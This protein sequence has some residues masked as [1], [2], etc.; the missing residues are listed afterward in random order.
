M[1]VRGMKNSKI[2]ELPVT[3]T[4]H[5]LYDVLPAS[6]YQCNISSRSKAGMSDPSNRLIAF[7]LCAIPDAP[8]SVEILKGNGRRSI[9]HSTS[10]TLQR[11][12]LTF[13]SCHFDPSSIL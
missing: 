13:S 4:V 3:Q 5:T 12:L 10:F 6:S 7:T 1:T 2:F 11:S 8:P 9:S